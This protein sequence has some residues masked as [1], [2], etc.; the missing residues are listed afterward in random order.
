LVEQTPLLVPPSHHRRLQL[1]D[2]GFTGITVRRQSQAFFDSIDPQ[3]TFNVFS[4]NRRIEKPLR[5]L[6][7]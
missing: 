4:R 3:R 2:P 1:R 7:R 5:P 6:L